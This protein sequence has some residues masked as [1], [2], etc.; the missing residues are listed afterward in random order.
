MR[1]L[2]VILVEDEALILEELMLTIPWE[3]IGLELLGTATNGLDGER[4]IRELDPDIVITD[5]RL[6]GKTGLDML[7]DSAV[8]R[9]IILSG[10]T[11]FQYMQKAIR[12]GVFDYLQ[13]PVDSD[14]LIAS[15]EKLRDMIMEDEN[16]RESIVENSDGLSLPEKIHNHTIRMA[17]DFIN[18]NYKE[19]IGLQDI[20]AVTHVTEN[21]ISTLFREET[22]MNFLQYL[23]IV[24]INKALPL[25]RESGMNITEIASATGFPTPGYFTK[26][27]RRFIGKTPSEYRNSP[28]PALRI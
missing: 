24:R 22:G 17:I 26:V 14:E 6:P 2:G 16:S 21:Y 27:F 23:S 9:G 5:I 8:D 19:S 11:D 4:I 20:A 18:Q 1:N 3:D 12:L 28:A 7:E 13:K 25:L 15:L 10:Y